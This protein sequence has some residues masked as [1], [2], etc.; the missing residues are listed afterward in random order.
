MIFKKIEKLLNLN[1]KRGKSKLDLLKTFP[2]YKPYSSGKYL[3]RANLTVLAINELIPLLVKL[4]YYTSKNRVKHIGVDDVSTKKSLDYSNNLKDIFNRNNSD[5]AA[6][7]NLYH[8]LYAF[9][10]PNQEALEKI[11]EIGLGTNNVD[12]VSNMGANGHPGASLRSFREFFPNAEIYGADVDKRILF[13]ERKI[14]TFHVDQTDDATFL[15][16]DKSIPDDFDLMIDD[17]L[18]SVNANIR[19]LLFFLRKI[20]VGGFA[21]VEDIG[22]SALPLWELVGSMLDEKFESFIYTTS[23]SQVFV[24]KKLS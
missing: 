18:H 17:G 11:F 12:V 3:D 23:K 4:G 19:S 2:L 7:A 14:K 5:K 16:L 22:E 6:E 9:L 8:L 24:V 13:S 20:K 21:V 15:E 10:L 1:G